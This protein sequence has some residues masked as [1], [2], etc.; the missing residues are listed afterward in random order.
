MSRGDS[1]ISEDLMGLNTERILEERLDKEQELNREVRALNKQVHQLELDLEQASA[2]LNDKEDENIDLKKS[3]KK[4][5]KL[6]EE[7]EEKYTDA[8]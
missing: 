6:L 2:A 1:V 8:D 4:L 7:M 5:Q 3:S